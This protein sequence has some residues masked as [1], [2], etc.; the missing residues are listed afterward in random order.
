MARV[1]RLEQERLRPRPHA[2]VEHFRQ[3][4]VVRVRALVI[5]PADV[6][7]HRGGRNVARRVVDRGDVALGDPQEFRIRQVLILVVPRRAEIGRI[8][9]QNKAGA[10]NRLVFR[11]QRFGERFNIGVFVFVKGVGDKF[12]QHPR[13]RRVHKGF[14]GICR[15]TGGGEVLQ[16]GVE[17]AA[18]A[19]GNRAGAA[20]HRR[21]GEPRDA[22][23]QLD[24]PR[25]GVGMID[26][27]E[28]LRGLRRL[29]DLGAMEGADAGEPVTH[30]EGVGDLALLAVAD[31]VDA[32]GD[33]LLDDLAHR[34]REPRLERG[35]VEPLAGLACFEHRQEIGR[36]R[37]AADMRRQDAVGAELHRGTPPTFHAIW[38]QR[39]PARK[40]AA[41][42]ICVLRDGADPTLAAPG[43]AGHRRPSRFGELQH[44]RIPLLHR[45]R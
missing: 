42:A 5:A 43:S 10:D 28:M 26:Q 13:R 38:P 34:P 24:H 2:G 7:A 3:R 14:T 23:T 9:L 6:Q 20:R 18:V 33:L 15:G 37:Q 32:A 35:L 22:A 45:R 8:D 25:G 41:A 4:D 40:D 16:I 1:G 31:A 36:A 17:R 39:S 11:L 27:I 19:I 44:G 21:R 12:R 30:I 29:V